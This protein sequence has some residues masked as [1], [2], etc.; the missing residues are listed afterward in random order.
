MQ[1]GTL[2]AL[3]A[4]FQIQKTPPKKEGQ[5]ETDYRSL[6]SAFPEPVGKSSCGWFYRHAHSIIRFVQSNPNFVM[7]SAMQN[8]GSLGKGFDAAWRIKV[9]QFQ[10]PL[11]S[12]GTKGAWVLQ[13][14]DILSDALEL[15][16]LHNNDIAL[17]FAQIQ[18]LYSAT[19]KGVPEDVL[20]TLVKFYLSNKPEDSDWVVLPVTNFDAY[21]GTTAFSRKWLV[22]IPEGIVLREHSYGVS[23]YR[24]FV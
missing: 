15:G 14:D 17:S 19:P 24:V 18:T 1:Q 16:K 21:F 23:R 4:A 20:P 12:A 2:F 10:V 5:S 13:F 8:C 3:G 22:I 7:K 6:H 9:I 11:C